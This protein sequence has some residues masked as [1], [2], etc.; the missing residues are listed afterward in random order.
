MLPSRG[1]AGIGEE[2]FSWPPV[3]KEATCL[4]ATFL[5]FYGSQLPAKDLLISTVPCQTQAVHPW[6]PGTG[7]PAPAE[8]QTWLRLLGPVKAPAAP[9]QRP[10]RAPQ[11]DTTH[12]KSHEDPPS[13]E[14]L[15]D[16]CLAA[17]VPP[18][19]D[20]NNGVGGA[21]PHPVTVPGRNQS[22]ADAPTCTPAHTH[23]LTARAAS[24]SCSSAPGVHSS[25]TSA[26]VRG[27]CHPLQG[28]LGT[29]SQPHVPALSSEV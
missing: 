5:L 1:D 6:P 10:P 11:A 12:S 18:K 20:R 17:A 7:Y 15:S 28:D 26:R 23:R 29:S 27:R 14:S 4:A 24:L 19:A 8:A 21:F 25:L 16:L 22:V 2:R 3:W 9:A 13:P